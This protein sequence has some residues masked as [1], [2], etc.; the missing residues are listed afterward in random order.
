MLLHLLILKQISEKE[1]Q[2]YFESADC[3]MI[4]NPTSHRSTTAH[5]FVT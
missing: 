3:N 2:N 5:T 1:E 4:T